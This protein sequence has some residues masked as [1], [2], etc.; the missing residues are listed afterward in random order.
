MKALAPLGR[1]VVPATATAPVVGFFI[2]DIVQMR[3]A[4]IAN[5]LS[6]R[7]RGSGL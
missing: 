1:L 3:L 5:C 6:A 2:F 7:R 4:E